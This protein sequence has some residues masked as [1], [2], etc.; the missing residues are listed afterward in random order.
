VFDGALLAEPDGLAD[1]VE[2]VGLGAADGAAEVSAV[3]R[4]RCG[5]DERH[6]VVDDFLLPGVVAL[7]ADASGRRAGVGL[8]HDAAAPVTIRLDG[9][10]RHRKQ[11]A[12]VRLDCRRVNVQRRAGGSGG[13]ARE[14]A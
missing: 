11:A 14:G 7:V 6:A 3:D 10:L 8:P 9:K 4:E 2:D 13:A 1:P 5:L 12:A